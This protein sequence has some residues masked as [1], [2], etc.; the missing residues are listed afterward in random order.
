MNDTNVDIGGWLREAFELYKAHLVT[1]LL[2][3]LLAFA[4]SAITAGV[5]A[6]P[7]YAGVAWVTLG[8]L[9]RRSPAAQPADVIRGLQQ[10][11][12][13][14]FLLSLVLLL[15]L[16]PLA[17]VTAAAGL[18]GHLVLAP[19]F[20][21]GSLVLGT[22]TVFAIFLIVDRGLDFWPAIAASYAIVR[23]RFWPMLGLVAVGGIVGAAGFAVCCIG[24]LVTLPYPVCVAAVAYRHLTGGAAPAAE[25]PEQGAPRF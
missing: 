22:L 2:A 13:P 6:G 1:L 25:S 18:V 12:L 20:T 5:L 4:V 23:D 7:M 9:D 17:V 10:F 16:A 21:A 11:F 3:N 14:A 15:P 24:I 8:A 19:L